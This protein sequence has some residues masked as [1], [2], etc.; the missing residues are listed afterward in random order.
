MHHEIIEQ[1][2]A[3]EECPLVNAQEA[4]EMSEHKRVRPLFIEQG[5]LS[6]LLQRFNQ[7]RVYLATNTKLVKDLNGAINDDFVLLATTLISD[8][9]ILINYYRKNSIPHLLAYENAASG[10]SVNSSY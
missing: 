7:E 2:K 4:I 3:G 8:W 1:V 6:Y 9:R 10:I 5:K